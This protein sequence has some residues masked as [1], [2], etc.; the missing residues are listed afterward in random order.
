M[1]ELPK[2]LH[3]TNQK[4]IYDRIMAWVS[5]VKTG[6][7]EAT[8]DTDKAAA[9]LAKSKQPAVQL[10][11]A[12]VMI[13]QARDLLEAVRKDGSLASTRRSTPCRR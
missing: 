5:P 3:F 2:E 8:A 11:Q 9:A 6:V 1:S 13:L 7:A 12:Q 10:A 4:T